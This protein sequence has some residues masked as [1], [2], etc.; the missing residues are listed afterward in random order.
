MSAQMDR[1]IA[2]AKALCGMTQSS[3]SRAENE[4]GFGA[5]TSKLVRL[6]LDAHKE[7]A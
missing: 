3:V 2:N 4:T 6:L 5:C 7:D 1:I